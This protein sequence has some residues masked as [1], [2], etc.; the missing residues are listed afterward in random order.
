MDYVQIDDSKFQVGLTHRHRYFLNFSQI[1]NIVSNK[2][3][4]RSKDVNN[5]PAFVIMMGMEKQGM[6]YQ[7]QVYDLLQ[8][9]GQLGGFIEILNLACIFLVSLLC[10]GLIEAK[11]VNVFFNSTLGFTHSHEG[12]NKVDLLSFTFQLKYFLYKYICCSNKKFRIVIKDS[13]NFFHQV[14]HLN[15]DLF[16]M[17]QS[18]SLKATMKYN[19]VLTK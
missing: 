2:S 13:D 12:P 10:S 16:I 3:I 1:I 8:F 4:Y 6:M 5:D 11:T 14:E 7:R 15:N 18:L 9:F 19:N 17:N